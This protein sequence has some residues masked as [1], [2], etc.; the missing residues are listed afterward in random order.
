M[1]VADIGV[2]VYIFSLYLNN[3]SQINICEFPT[4]NSP[5]KNLPQ[6]IGHGVVMNLWH[7][8]CCDLPKFKT[9]A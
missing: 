8:N 5:N 2:V 7:P 6:A 4:H 1:Y 3:Y 9:R